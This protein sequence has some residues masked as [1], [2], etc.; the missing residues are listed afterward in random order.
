MDV[1]SLSFILPRILS[2]Q[3][4]AAVPMRG[5]PCTWYTVCATLSPCTLGVSLAS[6]SFL[7]AFHGHPPVP[8]WSFL[9][10]PS[11]INWQRRTPAHQDG[12]H[13]GSRNSSCI[14]RNPSTSLPS[15]P[16]HPGRSACRRYFLVLSIQLG[17][18]PR[19]EKK[20]PHREQ[21]FS[22]KH[23]HVSPLLARL[24]LHSKAR[25]P[26]SSSISA[27]LSQKTPFRL[28]MLCCLYPAQSVF[29]YRSIELIPNPRFET[30]K[31]TYR[32]HQVSALAP[33]LP[34]RCA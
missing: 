19:G 30:V 15:N 4:Q 20:A 12:S 6:I 10:A 3:S 5:V 24:L 2:S 9:L 13:S 11:C 16:R 27:S 32:L 25:P 7:S 29:A 33:Y 17:L 26:R 8:L 14:C 1:D 21:N 28:R 34:P 18:Y 31:A 22:L 23:T